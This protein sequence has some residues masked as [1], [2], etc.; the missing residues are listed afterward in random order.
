MFKKYR[1]HILLFVLT[2]ITTTFSGIEWITGK[3]I[4][5]DETWW[6]SFDYFLEGL[7]FSVPF[8]LFLTCHEFGHYFTARYYGVNVSLPYYIPLWLG[9]TLTIGTM[10]AFIQIKQR[11]HSRK[12][13]FDIGIAGPLAGF[14]VAV[15]ISWYGFANLPTAD[16]VFKIHPKYKTEYPAA[17]QKYGL[18]YAKYAYQYADNKDNRKKDLV[19]KK[20]EDNMGIGKNLM[21]ILLENFVVKDKSRLPHPNEMMHYPYLFAGFLALLFTALNL[22]PIG[23]LDGGHILYGLVGYEWHRRIAPILLIL[24][25]F[26]AGLGIFQPFVLAYGSMR[27]FGEFSNYFATYLLYLFLLVIIFSRTFKTQGTVWVVSLA[28]FTLQ[29]GLAFWMPHLQGYSGW[30]V[31]ALLL[32]RVLGVYHPPADIDTPLDT[33]RKILGWLSLLI[34]VLCFSPQPIVFE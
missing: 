9:F 12:H 17:Y 26:Y 15:G 11:L 6:F 34:F 7:H 31:F 8:L 16:Y 2:F 29:Y 18:D 25:V 30:L 21:F 32:G 22:M 27:S 14:V 24:F 3:T 13:F 4:L 23:Q 5:L 1:I 33:K 19:G 10:G 28:V 20:I